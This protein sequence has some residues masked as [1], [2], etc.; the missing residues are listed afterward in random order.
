MNLSSRIPTRC[1]ASNA[2]SVSNWK[3]KHH[4]AWIIHAR[5]SPDCSFV[6]KE[7]G[8]QF[9]EESKALPDNPKFSNVFK[10][11]GSFKKWPEELRIKPEELAEAGF[12]HDS[13]G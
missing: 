2:K 1:V 11:V 7:K 4:P 6:V 3:D 12:Y 9:V 10:R 5:E 13:E 8:K